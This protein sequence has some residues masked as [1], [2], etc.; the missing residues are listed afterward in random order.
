MSLNN[1]NGIIH[2]GAFQLR[3]NVVLGPSTNATASDV[4]DQAQ[5]F[6]FGYNRSN[7]SQRREEVLGR[8]Q[9]LS[10]FMPKA[11]LEQVTKNPLAAELFLALREKQ[12]QLAKEDEIRHKQASIGSTISA[13]SAK[14]HWLLSDAVYYA[15][16][17][18]S[19]RAIQLALMAKPT[20]SGGI[21][22]ISGLSG[23]GASPFINSALGVF[24]AM[25]GIA[26]DS[27]LK[28]LG[29]QPSDYDLLKLT[30][31]DSRGR[32]ELEHKQDLLANLPRAT[33]PLSTFQGELSA[34]QPQSNSP[35]GIQNLS[36]IFMKQD[37]TR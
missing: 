7:A 19:P 10:P 27:Y 11:E 17:N 22:E 24:S 6:V 12:Q 2:S 36:N 18:F 31:L 16:R 37:S 21:S 33:T 20:I 34:L 28:V 14:V 25:E 32:T 35:A 30:G 3:S 8:L 23:D 9:E 5:A 15:K 1:V 4:A 29:I 13:V 26:H